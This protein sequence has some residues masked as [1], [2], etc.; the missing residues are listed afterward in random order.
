MISPLSAVTEK[1]KPRVRAG[2]GF[3]GAT[4]G[5]NVGST[6]KFDDG[7]YTAHVLLSSDWDVNG[8]S[9]VFNIAST[10]EEAR[11][12]A[13][14]VMGVVVAVSI[15]L[16]G[17]YVARVRQVDMKRYPDNQSHISSMQFGLITIAF[18]DFTSD[19]TWGFK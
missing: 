5:A 14:V 2:N 7:L 1:I 10:E 4:D 16:A 13:A 3:A 6:E 11:D 18:A 9:T 17:F 19:L 12:F 8:K 15:F